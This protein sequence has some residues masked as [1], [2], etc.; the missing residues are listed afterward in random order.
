[1][2]ALWQWLEGLTI[3]QEIGISWWFPF[4]ESVHVVFLTL[5]FGAILM[6]DLRLLGLAAMSHPATRMV[7]ELVPWTLI[8][9]AISVPTG[10]ALFITRAEHYANN[11]AFRIKLLLILLAGINMALFH[12][13]WIKSVETWDQSTPPLPARLTGGISI[14]LWLGVILAGRWTGHLN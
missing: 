10:L 7:R 8:G 3:S 6:V 1:M 11:P 9:F 4:I 12:T 13:R 5:T 14:T 2:T